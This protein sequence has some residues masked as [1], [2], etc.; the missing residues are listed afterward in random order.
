[1]LDAG[2]L[3]E[4]ASAGGDDQAIVGQRTG[5]GQHRATAIGQTGDLG[6]HMPHALPPEE[7][8][9]RHHQILAPPQAG[10]D[11]DDAG[12]VVQLGA[13]SDQGD[14]GMRVLAAQGADG[15][16]AGKAGTQH[17]DAGG[18][19]GRGRHGRP[20]SSPVPGRS[21][22]EK[23]FGSSTWMPDTE[24]RRPGGPPIRQLRHARNCQKWQPCHPRHRPA[25]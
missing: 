10:R 1:V 7:V 4:E 15:G 12:Q 13:R 9:Q 3:L 6:R 19:D 25:L 8:L 24:R 17:S 21:E 11:P 5:G 18:G 20:L 14:L 2:Q 16:Q 23:R 22:E